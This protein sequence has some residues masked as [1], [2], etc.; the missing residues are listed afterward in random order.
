MESDPDDLTSDT[1]LQG[2]HGPE[3][4]SHGFVNPPVHRGST[5][6]FPTLEAFEGSLEVDLL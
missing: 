2:R 1:T 6:R 4:D 3:I 5:V